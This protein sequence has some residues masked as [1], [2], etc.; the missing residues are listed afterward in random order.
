MKFLYANGDSWTEGVEIPNSGVMYDTDKFYSTWPWHLSQILD[1]PVCVNEGLGAGSNDRIHRKTS[2]FIFNWVGQNKNPANLIIV[3]GWTTAERIE[4]PIKTEYMRVTIQQSFTDSGMETKSMRLLRD[5]YYSLHD[6][7]KAH[8][9]LVKYMID[10]RLLC[11]G[12]GI[13]FYDFVAIGKPFSFFEDLAFN[14]YNLKLG[15]E[16]LSSRTW[17]QYVSDNNHTTYPF[18]H[19]TIE[20]HKLWAEHLSKGIK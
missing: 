19:P 12:L 10:L 11:K 16:S 4:I 2:E 5:A 14:T 13:K 6:D 7:Y 3:V 8:L 18:K 20:T 17:N 1:I 15:A 9:K